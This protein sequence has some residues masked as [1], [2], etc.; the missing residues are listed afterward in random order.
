MDL[1]E[2][3]NSIMAWTDSDAVF[4]IPVMKETIFRNGRLIVKGANTFRFL[5]VHGGWAKST[6]IA[7]GGLPM[8]ADFMTYFPAYIYPSTIKNCREYM[9]KT[10]KEKK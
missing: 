7:L 6:S 4:T 9:L 1:Y 8:I 2:T 3:P 5:W 10:L